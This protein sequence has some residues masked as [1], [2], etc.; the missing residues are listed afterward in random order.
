MISDRIKNNLG[1]SFKAEVIESACEKMQKKIDDG[2][3]KDPH[4][5][6]K[7]EAYIRAICEGSKKDPQEKAQSYKLYRAENIFTELVKENGKDWYMETVGKINELPDDVFKELQLQ[8][9]N[10]WWYSKRMIEG[11]SN[12]TDE[13]AEKLNQMIHEGK[14]KGSN[15]NAEERALSDKILSYQGKLRE[16]AT[17]EAMAVVYETRYKNRKVVQNVDSEGV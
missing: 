17:L 16:N 6:G 8:A 11:G 7:V 2:S 3:F 15:L 14:R 4:N 10:H 1:L 12:L 5:E 9:R 13:E